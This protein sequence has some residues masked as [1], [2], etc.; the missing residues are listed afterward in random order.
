MMTVGW[1]LIFLQQDKICV[2]IYLY[3]ENIEKLFSKIVLKT[4]NVWLK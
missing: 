4:Y 1:P 2:L 3:G